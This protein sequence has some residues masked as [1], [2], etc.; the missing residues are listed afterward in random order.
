M[1]QDFDYKLKKQK[2][3]DEEKAVALNEKKKLENPA[4]PHLTNLNE[5]P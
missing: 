5:D 3:A 4:E 1:E 2:E